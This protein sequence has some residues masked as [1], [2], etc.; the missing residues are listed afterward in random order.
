MW[1]NPALSSHTLTHH[2]WMYKV[3]R[4]GFEL[5]RGCYWH[6]ISYT[7]GAV[8]NGKAWATGSSSA[9]KGHSQRTFRGDLGI[10]GGEN[11]RRS[12]QKGGSWNV[13][14]SRYPPAQSGH[15]AHEHMSTLGHYGILWFFVVR[16]SA[17]GTFPRSLIALHCNQDYTRHPKH[18]NVPTRSQAEREG[19]FLEMHH[20]K[21]SQSLIISHPHS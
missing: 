20:S 1:K 14:Q 16:S 11:H 2:D 3:G 12:L 6:I 8:V 5:M 19:Q 10:D 15:W 9:L 7:Q 4:K 17:D 18:L 21:E 13:N